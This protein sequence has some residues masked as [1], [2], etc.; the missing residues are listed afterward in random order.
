VMIREAE[1]ARRGAKGRKPAS[2]PAPASKLRPIAKPKIPTEKAIVRLPAA[3]RQSELLQMRRYL[4]ASIS[5]Q[6]ALLKE[7]K[8]SREESLS[9]IELLQNMYGEIQTYNE[10]LLS[11]N[12]EL[13]FA[14][15]ELR[16]S[17]EELR[18][19][20]RDLEDRNR[21]LS[22]LSDEVSNVL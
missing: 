8:R 3:A 4:A 15:E 14:Q 17:N 22:R 6:E 7:L 12:E 20:N 9:S 19:L 10:E 21:E 16:S 5:E 2:L 1:T 13:I 18:V 11:I